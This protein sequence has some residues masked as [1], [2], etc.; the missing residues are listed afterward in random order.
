[1]GIEVLGQH[2]CQHEHPVKALGIFKFSG[3]LPETI[4]VAVGFCLYVFSPGLECGEA[5]FKVR[6]TSRRETASAQQVQASDWDLC[7][8]S[9]WCRE[10][11]RDRGW[12]GPQD[13]QETKGQGHHKRQGIDRKS[14]RLN[15]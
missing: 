3:I 5:V 6:L 2:N 14:T 10:Q 8:F 9:C 11:V 1:M 12:R 7:Q 13:G 15:S 4:F